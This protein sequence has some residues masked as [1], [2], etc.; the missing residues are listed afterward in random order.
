M[1]PVLSNLY[2]QFFLLLHLYFHVYVFLLLNCTSTHLWRRQ[3]TCGRNICK[4]QFTF[5]CIIKI[6]AIQITISRYIVL[7]R[8]WGWTE[9][10]LLWNM[11]I[12][13]TVCSSLTSHDEVPTWLILRHKWILAKKVDLGV[14]SELRKTWWKTICKFEIRKKVVLAIFLLANWWVHLRS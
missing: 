13:E 2:F 6:Y 4:I 7:R 9:V 3:F 8:G 14:T 11:K 5:H 10:L 1:Q 12:D